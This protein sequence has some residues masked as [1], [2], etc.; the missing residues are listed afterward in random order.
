MGAGSQSNMHGSIW[1]KNDQT[2][3]QRVIISLYFLVILFLM[4][5]SLKRKLVKWPSP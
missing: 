2:G 3:R 1:S 5:F 4:L